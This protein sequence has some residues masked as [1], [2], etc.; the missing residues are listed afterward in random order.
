MRCPAG[1][2]HRT[3][4]SA[5][6]RALAQRLPGTWTSTYH[7]Y[8]DDEFPLDHGVWDTGEPSWAVGQRLGQH[9]VLDGPDRQ[10]LYVLDR[11][12]SPGQFLVVPPIP[13]SFQ[14]HHFRR[15]DEPGGIAVPGDP[16]RAA[17]DVV[18]RV[19]PRYQ[20]ALAAV[21][22]NAR[23]QPDPVRRAEPTAVTHTVTLIW[24]RDGA[25][26]APHDSVPAEVRTL[27]YGYGFQ[28]RPP[29]G[30]LLLPADFNG[31]DEG[32][33]RI[34]AVA[35]RLTEQ[36]FGVNLRPAASAAC[37]PPPPPPTKTAPTRSR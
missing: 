2:T 17:A 36:G 20:H 37:A 24:Y 25:F 9:A 21:R 10:Q 29:E 33:A 22:H 19:L 35:R 15:V 27:L 1:L 12:R 26:G 31:I 14:P 13:D 7:R 4:L 34:Q 5:F 18:R 3:D 16:A 6:A 30:A 23:L 8:T 11:Q 32:M 28:Y